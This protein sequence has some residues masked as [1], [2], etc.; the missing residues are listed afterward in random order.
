M[1]RRPYLSASFLLGAVLGALASYPLEAA[2]I[3]ITEVMY[4]PRD[5]DELGEYL[6]LWNGGEGAID[7]GGWTLSGGVAFTFP[8]GTQLEKDA[9]LV[10]ARNLERFHAVHGMEIR[11]L[12]PFQGELKNS[13]EELK[14]VDARGGEVDSVAFSDDA[15]WPPG[16]DGN[17]SSLERLSP[18]GPARTAEHWAPSPP[19]AEPGLP[20]GT[21][22]RPGVAWAPYL[23]PVIAQV[24]WSPQVPKA[25]A[26]VRVETLVRHGQPIDKV[27]LAYRVAR[28]GSESEETRIEMGRVPQQG[29]RFAATLPAAEAFRVI[30]FRVIA[31][32]SNGV[33]RSSPSPHDLRPSFSLFVAPQ[34]EPGKVAHAYLLRVNADEAGA[35]RGPRGGRA[36]PTGPASERPRL[37]R[38]LGLAPVWA[39]FFGDEKVSFEKLEQLRAV[40]REEAETRKRAIDEVLRGPGLSGKSE[41]G[42]VDE[43]ASADARLEKA[44]RVVLTPQE[45]KKALSAR[46]DAARQSGRG[47][48]IAQFV[49]EASG[50][51]QLGYFVGTQVDLDLKGMAE[52]RGSFQALRIEETAAVQKIVKGMQEGKDPMTAAGEIALGLPA[53]AAAELEKPLSAADRRKFA[54]WRAQNVPSPFG[55]PGRM[56]GA[57]PDLPSRGNTAFCVVAPD[58]RVDV[59]D[60]VQ[61]PQRTGGFKVRL[62]G[63]RMLRFLDP[64]T[65]TEVPL[66]TI[67]LI[68][69][70]EPRFILAEHLAYELYRRC[71]VP[72]PVSG[73]L[74]LWVDGEAQGHYLLVEQPN[75]AF[76]RRNGRNDKGNLYKVLWYGRG[77]VEQHEKKTNV[78]AGHDDLLELLEALDMAT[79]EDQWR[80]IDSRFNVDEVI[81]YFAASLCL[82][83]WDGFFNN[84]FAYHDVKGTGK[85][86]IYPWDEDKTWGF[87]D[88][89][90]PG[91]FFFDMPVDY[92][93]DGSAAPGGGSAGGPGARGQ[94]RGFA[95]VTPWWR[96][97][98]YFSGPF[99]A[100]RT[101][102]ARYMKRVREILDTIYTEGV[103]LPIIAALEERLLPEVRARAQALQLD[104]AAEEERFRL[105]LKSLRRHLEER[106]Q[107]LLGQK[108][109]QR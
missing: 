5:E 99:L 73:H 37:E 84:Y 47:F 14:L 103:F 58:G 83:N 3:L 86:E 97:P 92:G 45:V 34:E 27:E 98:G 39:L 41:N 107:F 76:L 9:R 65:K 105:D 54:R 74:R 72:S 102:R 13:G 20:P 66:R 90:R 63:D 35:A 82:S 48:G 46:R 8:A 12:G 29:G 7:L 25:G 79:G 43:I 68:Y 11:S 88:G 18:A 70:Y 94:V 78:D 95:A 44:L 2:G 96:P 106:R 61:A 19:A 56:V 23:P 22:G 109:L 67:N 69:E 26:A 24:D 81:G 91:E 28:E 108:E 42:Y 15:P 40:L 71:G 53:R 89:L 60:Y 17:G 36:G 87:H 49:K 21:P 75:R 10:V 80:V 77:V 62:H 30:R 32:D 16:A 4:H 59:H 51:D 1:R 31:R 33:E 55:G 52:A 93:I 38:K 100:N 101:V 85:W 50:L 104:P 64:F 57:S 6:E